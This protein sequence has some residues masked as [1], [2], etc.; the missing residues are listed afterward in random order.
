MKNLFAILLFL[1]SSSAHA[2]TLKVATISPEG[3]SWMKSM[4]ASAKEIEKKTEGRVK[5]KFYTGGVMGNDQAVLKKIRFRQLQGGALTSS[6]L[7]NTYP[8]S[9]LYTLPM[10]FRDQEEIDYVR[11]KLDQELLQGYE[12]NG[13]VVF[14][15]AGGGFAYLMSK[16]PLKT[17]DDVRS[18]KVWIPSN[19]KA[20]SEIVKAFDINPIPLSLGDVLPSLQTGIIDTVATSPIA[21][22]ALQWHTQVKYVIDLPILYIY[23]YFTVEKKAFNKLKPDD[24]K[25]FKAVMTNTFR[26][27]NEKNKTENE[28][29]KQA[30]VNFGIEYIQPA[31]VDRQAWYKIAAQ[32]GPNMVEQGRI[33]AD[34]FAK[35]NQVI[36]EYRQQSNQTVNNAATTQSTASN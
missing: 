10:V 1:I 14:G 19:D 12:D 3:S 35:L 22:I 29:A 18:H 34:L 28:A 11:A 32:V 30:L 9:Q 13:F 15:F 4:R 8:D 7:A 31:D 6:S 16:D 20:A 23:A 33:S 25:I 17:I 2:V 5:I 24:Q 27:I 21:A 36:E 26:E